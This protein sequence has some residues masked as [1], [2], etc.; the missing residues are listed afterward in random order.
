MY[1]ASYRSVCVI[2]L[3]IF[4]FHSFITAL[5]SIS[6]PQSVTQALTSLGWK[7]AKDDEILAL[8]QNSTWELTT[9]PVGKHVVSCWVYV[10][11]DHPDG[12]VERLKACLVAKG[13]TQTFG[14]D[15]F[16]T[17]SP[18]ARLTSIRILLSVVV[19]KN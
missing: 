7:H 18:M 19:T 9:H 6:V 10:V 14:V 8:S 1:S 15:Y 3:F 5:S 12:T 17:F 16:E 13:Y 11:K 2:F 4:T